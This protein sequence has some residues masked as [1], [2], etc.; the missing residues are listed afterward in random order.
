MPEYL[1]VDENGH[2]FT[3]SHPMIYDKII[4]CEECQSVMWKKPQP[5]TVTWGGLKPSAGGLHPDIAQHIKDAP[6]NQAQIEK[7]KEGYK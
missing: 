7:D 1:Y 5:F 4:K 3:L 2:E 6:E